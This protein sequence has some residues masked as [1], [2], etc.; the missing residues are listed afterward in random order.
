MD[1]YR[2]G[3]VLRKH[4]HLYKIF[5]SENSSVAMTDPREHK[6]RRDLISPMFQRN[7]V[8]KSVYVLQR[9][10]HCLVPLPTRVANQS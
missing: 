10:V 9:K 2:M 7:A 4:P 8:L 6:I 3:S 1:I 5:G